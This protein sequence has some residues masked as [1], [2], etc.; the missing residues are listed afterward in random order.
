MWKTIKEASEYFGCSERTIRR[1]V[2]SGEL[3]SKR[4]GR[5]LLVLLEGED[6]QEQ[7]SDNT[8]A[9]ELGNDWE[10]AFVKLVMK[11]SRFLCDAYQDLAKDEHGIVASSWDELGL[12]P[13]VVKECE[14]TIEGFKASDNVFEIYHVEM[15]R[16]IDDVVGMYCE[17]NGVRRQGED[18]EVVR[19][20]I[21]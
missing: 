2:K 18:F 15:E 9:G 6:E 13:L 14:N 16:V 5:N 12:E 4:E 1:R 11:R 10:K 3:K 8:D 20:L 19:F 7:D 21:D 17:V